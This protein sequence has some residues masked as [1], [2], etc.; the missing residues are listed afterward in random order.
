MTLFLSFSTDPS[1]FTNQKPSDL[2]VSL[3]SYVFLLSLFCWSCLAHSKLLDLGQIDTLAFCLCFFRYLCT[4]R[5]WVVN[6][7]FPKPF[8]L[9]LLVGSGCC[10]FLLRCADLDMFFWKYVL[11][12]MFCICSRGHLSLSLSLSHVPLAWAVQMALNIR[13]L[14][15]PLSDCLSVSPWGRHHVV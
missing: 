5:W 7:D 1:F 13:V 12:R 2:L 11:H 4:D 9:P 10:H 8:W 3:S 6:C 15:L 14:F